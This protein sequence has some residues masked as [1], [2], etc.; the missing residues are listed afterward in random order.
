MVG[1]GGRVRTAR[2][3]MHQTREELFE[4]V[5]ATILRMAMAC[6]AILGK[7]LRALAK[8][9]AALA[10]EVWQDDIEIDRLDVEVDEVVLRAIALHA[11]VAGDLRRLLAANDMATDLERVGDLSRNIAKCAVRLAERSPVPLPPSLERL[12]RNA[13][14]MLRSALDA[15]VQRDAAR[16]RQLVRDDEQ[17]DDDQDCVVLEALDEIRAHPQYAAQAVDLILTAKHLERVGDH[18]TNIA[19]AVIRLVEGRNV[20]HADKLGTSWH[21]DGPG[22]GE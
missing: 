8:R 2:R 4:R 16:A 21:L 5:H 13:Q 6:E 12:T 7:A 1:A 11:P 14:Q 10:R 20:K 18:A 9:E 17:V 22:V 15:F 19:E 3:A